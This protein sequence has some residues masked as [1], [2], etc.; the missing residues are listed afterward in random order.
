M[1]IP[2]RPKN[3]RRIAIAAIA[4]ASDPV[5]LMNHQRITDYWTDGPTD[6]E[7]HSRVVHRRECRSAN[8][9]QRS[10]AGIASY[11]SGSRTAI[12]LATSVAAGGSMFART[13]TTYPD[14]KISS[15]PFM[16]GAPPP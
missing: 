3:Y 10:A 11:C 2:V 7:R 16:P 6:S 1:D 15:S 5:V 4:L 8:R 9:D 12:N 14:G 13:T